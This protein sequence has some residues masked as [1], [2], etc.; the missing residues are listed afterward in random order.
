MHFS[1][2]RCGPACDSPTSPSPTLSWP[3]RPGSTATRSRATG[4]ENGHGHF[5]H[6]A[7]TS[8]GP[9]ER[10][11]GP[12]ALSED[13]RASRAKLRDRQTTEA[14]TQWLT[15]NGEIQDPE[16]LRFLEQIGTERVA[17]FSTEDFLAIDLIDREMKVTELLKARIPYSTQSKRLTTSSRSSKYL[18]GNGL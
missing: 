5:D 16:F 8:P 15:L 9:V 18:K 13:R 11:R 6:A 3:A 7:G 17:A 10:R 12:A 1:R 4:T 2:L 14:S